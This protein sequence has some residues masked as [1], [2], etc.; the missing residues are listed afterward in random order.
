MK[1][2]K[3]KTIVV[4]L[5]PNVIQKNIDV[6]RHLLQRSKQSETISD[7]PDRVSRPVLTFSSF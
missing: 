7:S 3:I 2:L 5:S 1:G 6:R 4:I